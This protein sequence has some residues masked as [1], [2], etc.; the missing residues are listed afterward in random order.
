LCDIKEN[1][2]LH[3]IS[4]VCTIFSLCEAPETVEIMQPAIH[5]LCSNDI[6]IKDMEIPQEGVRRRRTKDMRELFKYAATNKNQNASPAM[7][8]NGAYCN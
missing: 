3:A 1:P 7:L 2:P 8:K 6:S 5:A 4:D